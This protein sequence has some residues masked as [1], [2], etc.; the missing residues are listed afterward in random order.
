MR[1]LTGWSED[2][3]ERFMAL[4][5]PVGGSP[6]FIAPSLHREQL[7][8]NPAGIVDIRTWNDTTGWRPITEALLAIGPGALIVEDMLPS[9]HLLELQQMAKEISFRSAGK[10]MSQLREVKSDD[11]L[12][13]L[14]RSAETADRV[15][16]ESLLQLSVGITELQLKGFVEEAFRRNGAVPAFAIIA[17]GSNSALPHHASGSKKL[18]HGDIV[19]MDI[20]CSLNHYGSD[21]TRTVAFGRPDPVVQA[22]YDTTWRAQ[23]AARSAVHPGAAAEDID[24]A[25][26]SVI[27]IEGFGD[28][29][30]HRTGHGIGLSVHEPPYIVEGNQRPLREG[31]CFSVEPGIYIPGRYGVR[32]ENIVTVTAQG[33]RSLNAEPCEGLQIV[34]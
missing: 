18:E 34:T 9:M 21:I 30:I 29:F 19:L 11:E 26:R 12:G 32:I 5:I 4:Y 27:S 14:T 16:Q 1:Y 13:M 24:R 8:S 3:H 31:M 20:G 25:A 28:Q 33:V 22:I 7:Q 2:A 15:Y 23:M 17:F 6:C 10:L